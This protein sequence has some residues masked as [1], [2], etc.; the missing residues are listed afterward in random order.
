MPHP[1]TRGSEWS[2]PPPEMTLG[3]GAPSSRSEC[4]WRWDGEAEG[5]VKVS[6]DV[7]GTESQLLG[8]P[9]GQ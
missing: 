1:G 5:E 9:A 3:K 4:T 8:I 7:P 2:L 6:V